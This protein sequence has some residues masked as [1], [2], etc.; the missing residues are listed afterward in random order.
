MTSAANASS[1][2]SYAEDGVTDETLWTDADAP[3]VIPYRRSKT[4]AERA[5]WDC[6][7]G[8]DTALATI[9]P[10]AVFGPLLDDDGSGSV[11]IIARL[12]GGK[13]P[14]IPHIGFEIVD[15]RDLADL[16][17]L[18]MVHDA[19][20]GE[21]FL[22]TGSFMWMADIAAVLRRALGDAA[23][24]VPT[25]RLPDI[26][27]RVAARFRPDLREIAVGLGRRNR[28]TTAKAETILG[29]RTR[30][31]QETLEDCARSLIDRGLVP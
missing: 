26:V 30:P 5:A 11:Q 23:S 21:R 7:A 20:A 25:R 2:T 8:T 18:A 31:V 28:H 4:L 15:V 13:M 16:H 17:V 27:V 6:V 29:W 24:R 1:P 9:L 19:A 14:G 12:L 22:A 3:G 10:G